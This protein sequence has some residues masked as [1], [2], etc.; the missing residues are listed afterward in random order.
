MIGLHSSEQ[1]PQAVKFAYCM[2]HDVVQKAI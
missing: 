2:S 1:Q